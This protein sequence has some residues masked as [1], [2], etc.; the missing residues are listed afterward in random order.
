MKTVA[1]LQAAYK[2]LVKALADLKTKAKADGASIADITAYQTHLKAM[3]AAAEELERA[4]LEEKVEGQVTKLAGAP[5]GEGEVGRDHN[6]R[7][8]AVPKLDVPKEARALMGVAAQHHAWLIERSTGEKV[9]W[10]KVLEREGYG[11]YAKELRHRGEREMFKAGVTSQTGSGILL[12]KPLANEI[13]P[14]LYPDTIFLQGNPR[15]VTFEAGQ[16]NQPRGAGSATAGYVAEGAKKPVGA[17]NFDGI[18]MYAK[19]LAGIVYMTNEAQ[20]WT[21]GR[22][23]EFI[24]ADLQETMGQKMDQAMLFGTGVGATP[25]GIFNQPG[26]VTLNGASKTATSNPGT[27]FADS[28]NPTV[29]ELDNFATFMILKFIGANIKRTP[30]FKWIMGYRFMMYLQNLRDGNGNAIYPTMQ[31][32]NPT[33]KNIGVLMSTN[34]PENAGA[35]TD[36]GTVGLVDFGNVLYGEDEG[37][38]MRTSTEA[39][40]LDSD[41]TTV[42]FLWQ[43]NKSAVLAEMMHGVALQRTAAV[44]VATGLR[45]G[46][47]STQA[48]TAG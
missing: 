35:T 4:I 9:T 17:P 14:I 45:A 19:K 28:R 42:V 37:M 38:T 1:E 5:A 18:S 43:E 29:G 3:I 48:A 41:G 33:W 20:R 21:V 36:Q 6:T 11:E 8:F 10:D 40:I 34:V 24:R 12:P 30:R 23:E 27:F 13:I 26:V 44:V 31:G 47:T 39:S 16:Y 22:L 32:D 15:R 25:L 46:S 7:H 2:A